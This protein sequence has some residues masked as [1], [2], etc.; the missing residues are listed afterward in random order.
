[1]NLTAGD[2]Y[3]P[4]FPP[5]TI[6]DSLWAISRAISY[7]ALLSASLLRN[8]R[9]S[10]GV[11]AVLGCSC[12]LLAVM[13]IGSRMFPLVCPLEVTGVSRELAGDLNFI[14]SNVLCEG[15]F[16]TRIKKKL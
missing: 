8:Q 11:A 13:T 16:L 1:M 15:H 9:R 4:T 10:H 7:S 3:I 14:R 6:K 12:F 5:A 2:V